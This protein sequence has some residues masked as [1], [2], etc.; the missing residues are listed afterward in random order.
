MWKAAAMA[1]TQAVPRRMPPTTSDMKCTPSATREN[2]TATTNK[3]ATDPA[4]HRQAG[5]SAGTTRTS[6][7]SHPTVVAC[8]WPL[9]NAAP[10]AVATGWGSTG[11]GRSTATLIPLFSSQLPNA[12]AATNS[13]LRKARRHSSHP[14]KGVRTIHHAVGEPMSVTTR[15]ADTNAGCAKATRFSCVATSSSTRM[16]G[17]N[18]VATSASTSA[19]STT[20]TRAV[21]A[22]VARAAAGRW[23]G[24]P[25]I[26]RPRPSGGPEGG[27][28]AHR[29]PGETLAHLAQATLYAP[30][31][32]SPRAASQSSTGP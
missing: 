19:K 15:T 6:S 10:W 1:A 9:G 28:A 32:S 23:R 22:S 4:S 7:T 16:S 14:V 26:Q 20:T 2:A 21:A 25:G 8:A 5:D 17:P 24:N 11:R 3:A 31:A 30:K 12:V 29:L 18:R 13:A 27:V